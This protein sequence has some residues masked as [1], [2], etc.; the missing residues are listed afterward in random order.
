MVCDIPESHGSITTAACQLRAV[1]RKRKCANGGIMSLECGE[2]H[3]GSN[4]P[5]SNGAIVTPAR[6]SATVGSER[7]RINPV[8]MTPQRCM[9]FARRGIPQSDRPVG[10]ARG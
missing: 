4:A 8:S 7:Q 2:G 3:G 10:T 5:K 9:H 1:G 6:E